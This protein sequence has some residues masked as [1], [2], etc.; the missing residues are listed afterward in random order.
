MCSINH[1]IPRLLQSLTCVV[2]TTSGLSRGSDLTVTVRV[3]LYNQTVGTIE[4]AEP[5]NI[6]VIVAPIAV[7]FVAGM[8]FFAVVVFIFCYK[9]HQKD[10]RYK[11]LIVEMEKLESSVARECKQGELGLASF[12]D[13]RFEGSTVLN[14]YDGPPQGS[15]NCRLIWMN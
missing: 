6:V 3:G 4:I 5:L 9:A 12:G 11:E 1:T 2:E 7:M 14:I 8:I 13:L 10:S 15:P